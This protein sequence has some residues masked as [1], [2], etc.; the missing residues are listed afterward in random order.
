MRIQHKSKHRE[1]YSSYKREVWIQNKSTSNK[2]QEP[3]V[4]KQSVFSKD[5]SAWNRVITHA[6]DKKFKEKLKNLIVIVIN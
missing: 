6:L 3:F 2:K 5:C 1:R 4:T